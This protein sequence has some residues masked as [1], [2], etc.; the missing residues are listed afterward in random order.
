MF[1]KASLLILIQNAP[2]HGWFCETSRRLRGQWCDSAPVRAQDPSSQVAREAQNAFGAL[3]DVLQAQRELQQHQDAAVGSKQNQS[4]AADL[5]SRT[6]EAL[7][8]LGALVV[9]CQH[10]LMLCLVCMHVEA[11]LS[12]SNKIAR[13]QSCCPSMRCSFQGVC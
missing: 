13:S 2:L 8:G 11:S 9:S 7:L 10:R 3:V 5:L 1:G 12:T 6:V 4:A